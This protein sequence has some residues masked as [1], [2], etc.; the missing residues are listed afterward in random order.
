MSDVIFVGLIDGRPFS[1]VTREWIPDATISPYWR[2]TEYDFD[3]CRAEQT[4]YW[5]EVGS[6]GDS[7]LSWPGQYWAAD[8]IDVAHEKDTA[9]RLDILPAPF[10]VARLFDDAIE[11]GHTIWCGKCQDHYPDDYG[12]PCAHVWWC[13]ECSDWSTPDERCHYRNGR[14][15]YQRK[16]AARD[17]A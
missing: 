17:V 1:V 14:K 4:L 2:R 10:T 3:W 13:D 9:E 8:G 15:A 11:T 16:R 7:P 12:N 5:H 6:G